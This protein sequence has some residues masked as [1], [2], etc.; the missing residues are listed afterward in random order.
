M[1][2]M[3]TTNQKPIIDIQ[4]IRAL[5]PHITVTKESYRVS[6]ERNKRGRKEQKNYKNNQK[7]INKMVTNE[8]LSL[9][10][11]LFVNV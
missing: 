8:Y 4:K 9:F 6:K 10:K 5:D 11:C 7:I 3:I 1:N 2:L